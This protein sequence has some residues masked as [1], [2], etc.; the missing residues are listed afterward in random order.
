MRSHLG[1]PFATVFVESGGCFR[2][3]FA[4]SPKPHD[5][6][7]APRASPAKGNDKSVSRGRCEF[8][9]Q[10]LDLIKH[11]GRAP[12]DQGAFGVKV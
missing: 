9:D 10:C 3:K 1:S 8:F 7:A 12:G 5:R 11:I 6:R 2:W 4:S